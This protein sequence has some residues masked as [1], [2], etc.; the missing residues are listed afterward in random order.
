MRKEWSSFGKNGDFM[1]W[2]WICLSSLMFLHSSSKCKSV[3]L[4]L[5]ILDGASIK[6]GREI[7]ISYGKLTK[8]KR[9]YGKD[10]L[11]KNKKTRTLE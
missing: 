8:K 10:N 3:V 4:R 9:S 11:T 7:H 5:D 1:I 6:F 2:A